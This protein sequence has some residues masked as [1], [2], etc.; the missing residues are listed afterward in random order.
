MLIA[1]G[2]IFGATLVGMMFD[3]TGGYKT[4]WLVMTVALVVATVLRFI[5]TSKKNRCAAIEVQQ[6]S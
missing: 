6:E 5:A 2:G 4:P 1:V 3:A